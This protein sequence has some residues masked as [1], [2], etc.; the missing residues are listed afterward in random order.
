MRIQRDEKNQNGIQHEAALRW[1][2][3]CETGKV[4]IKEKDYTHQ[5]ILFCSAPDSLFQTFKE[6]S[7]Y[8]GQVSYFREKGGHRFDY[9]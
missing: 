3:I 5:H 8:R 4:A 2:V 1:L 7:N 9:S 6:S